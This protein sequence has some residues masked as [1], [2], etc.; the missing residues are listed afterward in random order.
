MKVKRQ[1]PRRVN[2]KPQKPQALLLLSELA[3]ALARQLLAAAT[4]RHQSLALGT[5]SWE[6][7][8]G[9]SCFPMAVARSVA[10]VGN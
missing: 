4:W 2:H 3:I 8:V 9:R 6:F 7:V 10:I 1:W 5:I